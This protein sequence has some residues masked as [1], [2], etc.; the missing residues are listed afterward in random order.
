MKRKKK[1]RRGDKDDHQGIFPV[2]SQTK[3]VKKAHH[4]TAR[5]GACMRQKRSSFF[6]REETWGGCCFSTRGPYAT[7]YELS[8][9]RKGRKKDDKKKRDEQHTRS[10]RVGKVP[11][12]RLNSFSAQAARFLGLVILPRGTRRETDFL[13]ILCLV[14]PSI[15]LP[16][17]LST[18][19]RAN[20]RS[21]TL[22][23]ADG[24]AHLGR[25]LARDNIR[26]LSGWRMYSLTTSVVFV[27]STPR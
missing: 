6:V 11:S 25:R 26:G 18:E 22:L 7:V 27:L 21:G 4:C 16:H 2:Q 5:P 19:P 17:K 13:R 12:R 9:R 14:C 1:A 8:M 15:L 3:D 20:C 23:P 10:G 24:I